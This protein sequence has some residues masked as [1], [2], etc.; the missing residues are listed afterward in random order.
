[1][2]LFGSKYRAFVELSIIINCYGT[3]VSYLVAVTD[4]LKPLIVQLQKL[5]PFINRTFGL[6]VYWII[7]VVPLSL[8]RTVNNLKLYSFIG[9][10]SI[11][12]LIITCIV[13][14]V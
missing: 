8:R 11:I 14:S 5:F 2:K 13:L 4:L 7:I 9:V 12:Y 3:S 10:I 6:V 1:M